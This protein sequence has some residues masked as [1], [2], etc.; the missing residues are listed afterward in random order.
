[1]T[2][3]ESQAETI[4]TVEVPTHA[5][6][7]VEQLT[8]EEAAERHQLELR[9]EKAFYQ[10]GVALRSLRDRRL[11]RSSYNT[12]EEYCRE[13]FDFTRAA[14]YYLISAADVMDNLL[15]KCQQFV[16]ILPTKENQCRELAKL[17]PELQPE[18]W[19]ESVSRAGGRKV[20]PAKTIKSVVQ[21][22]KERNGTP[23]PISYAKG[24][25][26]EI[27]AGANPTL[28]KHDGCWGIVT[29]VGTFSCK[30]HISVRNINVQCKPDEMNQVDPKYTADIRAVHQRIT[31]LMQ[32]DDLSHTAT[33]VVETLV[34][35]TCFSPEDLWL[36]EK[37]EEWRGL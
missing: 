25:V 6:E 33:A 7:V 14:A 20:P 17:D 9:V 29:H 34:R 3:K 18:A 11:Y 31:A 21:E 37:I 24:D 15:W 22:I 23:P 19:L 5:V 13:R 2:P 12:F 27:R 28:R 32:R 4:V 36:L 8:E 30:V 16:D 35:Q 1:M 26:V 10:A